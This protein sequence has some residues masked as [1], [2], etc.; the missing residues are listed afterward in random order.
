MHIICVFVIFFILFPGFWD[1]GLGEGL[2]VYWTAANGNVYAGHY[3]HDE[4]NGYGEM[5]WGDGG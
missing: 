2:G 4:R 3:V 5:H 1:N